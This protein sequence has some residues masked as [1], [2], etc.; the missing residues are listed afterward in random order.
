M[1]SVMAHSFSRIP[2]ANIP[3]SSFDRSHGVKTTF[4]SG[5]L[6]P[7]FIDETLPGDTFNLKT[8]GF[9]RLST[10]IYPLMDNMYMETFFFHVPL[11]LVWTNFVKMMGEQDD[12]GDSTDYT[13]PTRTGGV[14]ENSIYDYFGW[15]VNGVNVTGE[16][17]STRAYALIWNEWFRDQNLQDSLV[18]DK[19]DSHV[20]GIGLQRR[21][22]RHDYFTSCLPWPQ[23]GDA[24]ELPLGTSA[25]VLGVGVDDSASAFSSDTFRQT[26]DSTETWTYNKAI[27][28]EVDASGSGSQPGPIYA[29]LST[30]TA[31]TV[32]QLR[33][34]FQIQKM[35]ERDARSG[36]RY[37]ETVRA[38]FGVTSPDARL[39]RPEYL[40]GGSTKINIHPVPYNAEGA[41]AAV[42]T[43]AAIGTAAF[44]G[45]GF[46]KSFT[47]HGII[48]GLVNVRA[49]ITYQQ[50][51][52][53]MF[54]RSDRLDFY[55]PALSMIGEQAVTNGEI[56]WQGTSADSDVFGYQE[57]YAEYRYK[58]STIHGAFRSSAATPLDAW[59]LS[60]EFSSLPT[61]GDTFIKD[62]PPVDRVVAV[63]TEPE[64]IADFYHKLICA[65]PMPMFGV[66]GMMDHF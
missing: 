16:V 58:P 26:D 29:D 15:P 37:I 49:D 38:H 61:L 2:S 10:P 23:K 31:A 6:I 53:R 36:T 60:Q 13:V 57:R 65:R 3:R 30:A 1:K 41:S 32:N 20:T 5:L 59:H 24:V 40:G 52:N 35:Y 19:G 47:E 39:Q 33:Q 8:S 54:S 11:R 17:L 45:H 14:A 9:A 42:G 12:P 55:W 46:T 64:F 44:D 4:D 27:Y 62:I 48:I 7:F 50:G 18:V 22:K 56:Y 28:A 43:L 34:A 25:N 63:N 51:L 21:G 66:P